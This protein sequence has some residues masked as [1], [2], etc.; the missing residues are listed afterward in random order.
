MQEYWESIE[1]ARLACSVS[2]FHIH[3]VDPDVSDRVQQL[4]IMAE[5][6]IEAKTLRYRAS[7][8]EW[9]EW[10][11]KKGIELP[12]ALA[13]AVAKQSPLPVLD[14]AERGT[15]RKASETKERDTMLRLIGSMAT[16]GHGVDLDKPHAAAARIVA[17][18]ENLEKEQ[19]KISQGT[20]VKYLTEAAQTLNIKIEK[21]Q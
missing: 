13:E 17:D 20:I 16:A 18:L 14:A 19:F 11:N 4:A 2:G 10:A 8:R 6:S 5:R 21:E 9:V 7:P 1:F 15:K 12:R 3:D